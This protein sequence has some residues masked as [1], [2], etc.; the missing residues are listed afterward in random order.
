MRLIVFNRARLPHWPAHSKRPW[1]LAGDQACVKN[2]PHS[3]TGLGLISHPF[4]CEG[5]Q[6]CACTYQFDTEL[7]FFRVSSWLDQCL[8]LSFFLWAICRSARLCVRTCESVSVFRL[9]TPARWPTIK[10]AT[11][12]SVICVAEKIPLSEEHFPHACSSQWENVSLIQFRTGKTDLCQP[13]ASENIL[14]FIS[15]L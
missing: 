2:P 9:V 14:S 12:L 1:P 6:P 8:C 5:S 10:A 7:F 4:H 15:N 3:A 11:P 13:C